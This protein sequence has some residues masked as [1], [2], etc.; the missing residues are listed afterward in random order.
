MLHFCPRR[1]SLLNPQQTK[2]RVLRL[3]ILRS[4]KR[5]RGERGKRE[6]GMERWMARQEEQ[7]W[8]F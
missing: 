8:A 4:L 6:R 2:N 7:R 5:N 1:S 3:D